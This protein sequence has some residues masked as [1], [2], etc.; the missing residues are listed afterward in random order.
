MTIIIAI[1]VT[2]I[3]FIQKDS[4]KE[5]DVRKERFYDGERLQNM[6]CNRELK[7]ALSFLD[8]LHTKYPHDPQFYFGEGWIHDMSD[9]SIKAR[10][11]F[12]KALCLYDS[13][14]AE[15]EDLGYR[16]NRAFIIDI[17]YGHDVHNKAIDSLLIYAKNSSDSANIEMFRDVKYDKDKMFQPGANDMLYAKFHSKS[18]KKHAKSVIEFYFDKGKITT[19]HFWGTSH[20][21][22]SDEGG[23]TGYFTLP[24]S[25]IKY[26][27]DNTVCFELDMRG[28]RFFRK[29][30]YQRFYSSDE[31]PMQALFGDREI[32]IKDSVI[33]FVVA[34]GKET[35][36]VEN[37]NNKALGKRVFYRKESH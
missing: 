22:T 13:L 1:A 30:P 17:L 7:E 24:L 15:K 6:L 36:T 9:D 31:V 18:D 26:V 25:H 19:G 27:N 16:I 37:Q 14:I 23:I 35:I 32:T 29:S 2:V 12:E 33:S 20:E 28:N 4:E 3:I 21:F 34:L 10:R 11:C 8:T 5:Y